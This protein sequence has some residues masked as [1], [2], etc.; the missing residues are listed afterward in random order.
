MTLVENLKAGKILANKDI[1][2]RRFTTAA[3]TIY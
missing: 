2:S 3:Y 1:V